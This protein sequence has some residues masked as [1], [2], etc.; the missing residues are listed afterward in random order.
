MKSARQALGDDGKAQ[1]FIKTIHGQGFRFVAQVE[2]LRAATPRELRTSHRPAE[3]RS[4]APSPVSRPSIAVLPFRLVAGDDRPYA[5]LAD[6]LPDELIT[7]LSRLRWLLVTARGSSFRLRAP[8]ADFGDIGRLLGVRY[9]LSGTVEV[10]GCEARRHGRAGRYARRCRRLGGSLRG[11]GSTTCTR[12]ARR[13]ARGSSRRSRSAFR[14]TKRPRAPRPVAENLDA[15]SAYHLGLQHMYRFNRSDNGAAP[16]LFERA[17]GT[18]PGFARAHA[19]L[20]F[21]HFQTAFMRLHGRPRRRRSLRHDASP[22]AAS[23]STRSTR[24]STSRWAAPTGSRAIST[25]SLGWLER[26][27]V[28]QPELRAGHLRARLDGGAAGRQSEGRSARRSG[29]APEPARSA[30]LRDARHARIHPHGL[31]RGRAKRRTGPSARAR[32]PGAHVLIAMIAA[33]AHALAGDTRAP[34]VGGQR[35]RAQRHAHAR[36]F[37][38]CVS[39]EVGADARPGFERARKPGLLAPS[40]RSGR[41]VNMSNSGPAG[42]MAAAPGFAA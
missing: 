27:T 26:A 8:D 15:W 12:C 21:V 38:P 7:D 2:A 11:R 3:R 5:A 16:G 14:C 23:N 18:R 19:G 39:D 31:G 34:L 35:A 10:V 22:S 29:D 33:A 42:V 32:S 9:C 37:L 25:R 41:A 4:H 17:V 40:P 1:R 36:G 6:A 20:S 28:D 13:S 30:V 24:S